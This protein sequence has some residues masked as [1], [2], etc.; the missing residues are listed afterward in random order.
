MSDKTKSILLFFFNMI[1]LQDI[2]KLNNLNQSAY[3]CTKQSRWKETT[4]KYLNNLLIEN[5]KL[6][7]E[8]LSYKYTI[9]PTVNFILNERG[10]IR[11]IESPSIR[12]R[13]I[14]KII[15]KDVLIPSLLPH[16]IY[17]NYASIKN[18]GVSFARKRFAI[19]LRNYILKNGTNGYILFIDIK[20]Y[21]QNIDHEILKK[22]IT[23]FLLNYDKDIIDLI[24]YIIDNSSNNTKGL[25]LGSEAPQILALYYLT[26]VDTFVKIVKSIKYY[27]RYMDDI[28]IISDSKEELTNILSD[29]EEI[30]LNLKLEIN[31]KKTYITKIKH[32]FT[33]L[34]IKYNVLQSGKILKRVSHNKIVRERRR[35]KALYRVYKKGYISIEDVQNCYKSWRG[36]I[37]HDHNAFY[38]SICNMDKLYFNLFGQYINIRSIGRKKKKKKAMEDDLSNLIII[39]SIYD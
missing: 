19:M 11:Y 26:P 27:G 30:L 13:I 34:Q 14:Q 17:D 10:H 9:S 36:N 21:F 4:Q 33:F 5:I 35:L 20:K 25:N 2:I 31:K 38:K 28:F 15:T 39:N 32:E 3:Q 8:V 24:Y 29:I 12:D 37:V 7:E 22:L 6:Q 23:P 1:T 18:R 16:V